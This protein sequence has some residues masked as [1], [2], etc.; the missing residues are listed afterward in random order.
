M[1]KQPKM[2]K[3]KIEKKWAC[4]NGH[5][6]TTVLYPKSPEPMFCLT[7]LIKLDELTK[8]TEQNKTEN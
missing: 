5:L 1:D 8:W 3:K 6:L 2:K 7:C 4:P